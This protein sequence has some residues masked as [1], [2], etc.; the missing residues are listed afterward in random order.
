[1]FFHSASMVVNA[2]LVLP[3]T[4]I[5]AP[6]QRLL[7]LVQASIHICASIGNSLAFIPKRDAAYVHCIWSIA[8]I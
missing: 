3:G 7:F 2:K 8:A 4:H 1:M 5:S 6:L